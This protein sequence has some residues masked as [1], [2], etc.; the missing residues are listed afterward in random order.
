M[1][2]DHKAFPDSYV[3]IAF[4]VGGRDRN[5]IDCWGL[6]RLV[7]AEQ[8]AIELPDWGALYDS[9]TDRAGLAGLIDARMQGWREVKMRDQ[10]KSFD[11]VLRNLGGVA[12]HIGIM[13]DA[14]FVLHAEEGAAPSGVSVIE[15]IDSLKW[16]MRIAGFYRLETG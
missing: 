9:A 2:A 11:G 10:V 12:S 14:R 16:C 5:G 1:R 3:G 6:L 7:Y 8:L 13:V 15:R 4:A